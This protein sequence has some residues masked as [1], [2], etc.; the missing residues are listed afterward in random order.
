MWYYI[1]VLIIGSLF[2]GYII[3]SKRMPESSVEVE[4]RPKDQVEG[5]KETL[6][7]PKPLWQILYEQRNA[8]ARDRVE[9]YAHVWSKWSEE[10][11]AELGAE[12]AAKLGC[13][14]PSEGRS[15]FDEARKKLGGAEW[16]FDRYLVLRRCM[17]SAYN[18]FKSNQRRIIQ[19]REAWEA[20]GALDICLEV[21]SRIP[22]L[23][24]WPQPIEKLEAALDVAKH[25]RNVKE[26]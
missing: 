9:R 8:E 26:V 11:I 3:Y 13:W 21:E 5:E 2:T 23:H 25:L 24:E 6:Q 17:E 10:V 19:L 12:T 16:N 18:T 22:N 4:P 20:A 7:Q 14:V 15:L 1:A